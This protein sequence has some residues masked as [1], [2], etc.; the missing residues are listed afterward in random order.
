MAAG[1]AVIAQFLGRTFTET[2]GQWRLVSPSIEAHM[3]ITE[4]ARPQLIET[5]H[6]ITATAENNDW[7]RIYK[8]PK[9][10][11]FGFASQSDAP[12]MD[13]VALV[14][15]K[16][17]AH[18][19]TSEGDAALE[20]GDVALAP[21][22]PFT[23]VALRQ[24]TP[25]AQISALADLPPH[26]AFAQLPIALANKPAR[27]ALRNALG[28]M[29]TGTPRF[30]D[31][32]PAADANAPADLKISKAFVASAIFKADDPAWLAAALAP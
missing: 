27:L 12:A 14:L 25:H 16:G 6:E 19:E 11:I 30:P 17:L 1:P 31:V 15:P 10:R 20:D 18:R 4:Q 13:T 23:R 29:E 9:V 28:A 26:Q 2:T 32:P 21:P 22:D 5:A 7:L 3:T 8:H 24:P